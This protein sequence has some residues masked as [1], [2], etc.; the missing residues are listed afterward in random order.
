MATQERPPTE[1]DLA[2]SFGPGLYTISVAKEGIIGLRHHATITV[3]WN[4]ESVHFV[5]GEPDIDY[6]NKNYGAGNYYLLKRP[7]DILPFQVY[8][9]GTPHDWTKELLEDG[10]S[11]MKD[12]HILVKVKLPWM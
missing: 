6:I 7:R 4:V 1:D 8:P 11:A 9:E 10:I 3:P 2:N 5:E 12:V